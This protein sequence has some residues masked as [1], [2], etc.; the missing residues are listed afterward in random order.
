MN[1]PDFEKGNGLL[2]V[3]IQHVDTQQV[4]MQ[5][6]MNEEAYQKTLN[7]RKVTFFS[8][9]KKRLWTKGE[10]SGHFLHVRSLLLDCDR[11]CLLIQ[12]D[13]EG[14]TCHVGTVT[15]WGQGNATSFSVL[16]RL[17]TTISSRWD[18]AS[19]S[20]SYVAHLREKGIAKIAQKVGEEAVETVIE[21]MKN[22]DELFLSESADL[23]FHYL[24]L[25]KAKG[26]SLED[27][28]TV[29]KTREK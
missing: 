3:V 24:I 16:G 19:S 20:D 9:T 12:A 1:Q 14:P 2:T 4:L 17:E 8:R 21:A 22:E 26:F 29:L 10:E 13:P 11:D 18:N 15:C 23:L 28:L 27:V 5:G 7:E 6:F 25:L